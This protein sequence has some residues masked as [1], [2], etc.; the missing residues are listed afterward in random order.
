MPMR[1]PR[2]WAHIVVIDGIRPLHC[3]LTTRGAQKTGLNNT[4]VNCRLHLEAIGV[5]VHHGSHCSSARKNGASS[6]GSNIGQGPIMAIQRK[7]SFLPPWK[8]AM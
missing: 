2:A 7:P 4:P 1:G 8:Q 5:V 6:F 3:L